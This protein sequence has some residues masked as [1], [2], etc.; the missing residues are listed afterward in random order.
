MYSIRSGLLLSV[1]RRW[2][3]LFFGAEEL[4]RMVSLED[5]YQDE[6]PAAITNKRKAPKK[7]VGRFA[8]LRGPQGSLDG[9]INV[10]C[11]I[12]HCSPFS[13]STAFSPLFITLLQY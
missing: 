12:Q 3:L 7:R 2:L 9:L 8:P 1:N 5:P 10:I 6:M 13:I 4:S 11:H